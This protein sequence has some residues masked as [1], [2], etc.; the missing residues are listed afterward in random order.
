MN[1][2]EENWQVFIIIRCPKFFVFTKKLGQ[3]SLQA[4][5]GFEPAFQK[6]NIVADKKNIKIFGAYIN[7]YIFV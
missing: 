2:C 6:L 1:C 7:F 5:K 4:G 3:R